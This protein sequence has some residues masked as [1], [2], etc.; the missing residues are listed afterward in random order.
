MKFEI[1]INQKGKYGRETLHGE[2]NSYMAAEQ[3]AEMIM[4][5]FKETEIKI[6]A[7]SSNKTEQEDE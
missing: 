3:L 1:E 6:M 2:V 7:R 4:A 5:G